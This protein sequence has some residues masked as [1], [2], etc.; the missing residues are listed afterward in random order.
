VQQSYAWLSSQIKFTC[1]DRNPIFTHLQN[2]TMKLEFLS[3]VFGLTR[4]E[5]STGFLCRSST[6]LTTRL[7]E[8]TGL[9]PSTLLDVE[10][11]LLVVDEE[12]KL[13]IEEY[14]DRMLSGDF[15]GDNPATI[16]PIL[17]SFC[18][19][20]S[21]EGAEMTQKILSE[22]ENQVDSGLISSETLQAHHYAIAIN[23]WAKSGAMDSPKK[24]ELVFNR[25]NKRGVGAN[26]IVYNSLMNAHAL[27]KNSDRVL[28]ILNLMERDMPTEL[29]T[30][31]YNVLLLAYALQG[32]ANAAEDVVK[33]MVDRYDRGE[34]DFL[35]DLVSYNTLLSA[36]TRSNSKN[37][38]SRAEMILD[39]VDGD[40]VTQ[41]DRRS[42][43]TAMVAV[44]RSG[45]KNV[46]E[47]VQVIWKRARKNGI[48]DDAYIL[49]TVLDAYAMAESSNAT[50]TVKHILQR[51]EKL[52]LNREEKTAVRN[53]ALK[54][55][56][57]S[58]DDGALSNAEQLFESM[59]LE[60]T[61]DHISCGTMITLYG[62]QKVDKISPQKVEE[63]MRKME[64]AG[65]KR[66]TSILN[67]LINVWIRYGDVGKAISLLDEMEQAFK[68]GIVSLAPNAISYTTIMNGWT[69][70]KNTASSRLVEDML[71]RQ[72]AMAQSGNKNAEP[73]LYSYVILVD[74]V[75]KSGRP[76]TAQ[77]VEKIVRD[78]YARY[79]SG[80]TGIKPNAQIVTSA[81]KCWSK[82]GDNN[83]GEQA[84]DIL[85]WLID[86]YE[87]ENDKALE[88]NNY[89][90]THGKRVCDV[91][92]H[93]TLFR[94]LI[95][96]PC[97]FVT[98]AISAWA[99]SRKFGKVWRARALLDEMTSLYESGKIRSSPN[100]YCYT[101]VI[102]ACAFCEN[103][104]LE[105]R[106]S[107][108]VFT[109]VYKQVI[110]D[111]NLHPNQAT[112]SCAI[113]ALRRLLPPSPAR[114]DAVK[115]V[116]NKC[117]EQGMCDQNVLKS[118]RRTIQNKD[119]E[120]LMGEYSVTTTGEILY[121]QLPFQ[122][123]CNVR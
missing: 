119:W 41:P 59:M 24:A 22:I 103:D 77:R 11:A 47:R 36:W 1:V 67:C 95:Q 46:V 110:S 75:I 120:Q 53:A 10:K 5:S 60:G 81:I 118:L 62:N 80:E 84:E 104:T 121:S 71:K 2:Q 54:V 4:L 52:E 8:S 74:S 105:K 88:P 78:L 112:F 48:T 55:Y 107:V 42:Y 43:V 93:I 89:A 83:A 61:V 106:D 17:Q 122:W 109:D 35:P 79:K 69:K 87:L 38:G 30:R 29:L 45:E 82:S 73:N 37:C 44:I 123:R 65:I 70:S 28:E 86:I 31:D 12:E 57:E 34:S 25:M 94:Q 108:K 13:S 14:T 7:G 51:A 39:T 97:F 49:S 68:D 18:N 40:Q 101:S 96:F 15:E 58:N 72:E 32:N 114:T 76:G 63:L 23:A 64:R 3:I 115:K 117:V 19:R 21:V 102:N 56:K 85:K 99:K 20:E 98:S 116:F 100:E 66:T 91:S 6:R 50:A 33:Q 16:L 113:V 26:R 27:C 9:C 90:F 92:A 111:P